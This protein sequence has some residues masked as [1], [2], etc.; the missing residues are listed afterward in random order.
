MADSVYGTSA[1]SAF[2]L[3]T[4]AFGSLALIILASKFAQKKVSTASLITGISLIGMAT[5]AGMALV[6]EAK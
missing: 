1:V 6:Q 2:T 4:G 5:F 3:L